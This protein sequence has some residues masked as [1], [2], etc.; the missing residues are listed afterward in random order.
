MGKSGSQG[1]CEVAAV[2]RTSGKLGGNEDVDS[3]S[4]HGAK[5]G[6]SRI[7]CQ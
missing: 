6:Y 7:S 5:R 4:S 3:D 1:K 2:R